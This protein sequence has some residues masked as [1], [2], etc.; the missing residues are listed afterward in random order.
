MIYDFGIELFWLYVFILSTVVML[1]VWGIDAHTQTQGT[2]DNKKRMTKILDVVAPLC[3][4]LII[5]GGGAYLYN[6]QYNISTEYTNGIQE[7]QNEVFST[8][9][10]MKSATG[11][12][13]LDGKS[14][15]CNRDVLI[16]Y[17][18]THYNIS[19]P[20]SVGKAKT[21]LENTK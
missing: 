3:L 21:L 18:D 15:E 19:D 14:D 12:V 11:C 5:L 6:I 17:M 10:G 9:F 4:T 2:H 16:W 13:A 20:E 8:D 1:V 7:I